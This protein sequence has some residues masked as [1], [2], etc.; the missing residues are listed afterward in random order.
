[1]Q[2][3]VALHLFIVKSTVFFIMSLLIVIQFNLN[4]QSSFYAIDSSAINS[5]QIEF[6]SLEENFSNE[7]PIRILKKS[8][9]YVG[10]WFFIVNMILLVLLLIKF[11][12]FDDYSKKSW[13]AWINQNLFFQFIREK[14]PLNAILY[15]IEFA[16]KIYFVS[17]LILLSL[18]LLTGNW[19]LK[20]KDFKIIY[21]CLVL[22]LSVKTLIA[23]FLS[24]LTDKWNEFKILTLMNI[25]FTSN[26]S[27]FLIPV[28]LLAVYLNYDLRMYFVFLLLGIASIGLF[29]Y[30]SRGVNVLRKIQIQLN[31]HFFIYLCAFEIVPYLILLK[32]LYNYKLV[33]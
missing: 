18:Y 26:F 31:V 3:K 1:M 5:L 20:F 8:D 21:A 13:N 22:F 27:W 30:I 2:K 4:A 10:G 28:I 6:P 33:T 16:L 7:V 12:V 14:N 32:V 24:F 11:L 25:V 19:E 9:A 23:A 29:I 17:I 15:T